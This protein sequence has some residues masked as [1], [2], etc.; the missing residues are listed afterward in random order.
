MKNYVIKLKKLKVDL[1][2]KDELLNIKQANNDYLQKC[3]DSELHDGRIK[4]NHSEIMSFKV[5]NMKN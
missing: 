1:K 5:E 4:Q 2:T 3:L